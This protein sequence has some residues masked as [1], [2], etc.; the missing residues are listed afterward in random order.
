MQTMNDGVDSVKARWRDGGY[1]MDGQIN[2]KM[3]MVQT[4]NTSCGG[5]MWDHGWVDR[6]RQGT[7][8]WI[9]S[10]QCDVMNLMKRR[11]R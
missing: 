1:G 8:E 7:T 5:V 6:R 10:Q 2:K 3:F 9:L 11:V 4:G